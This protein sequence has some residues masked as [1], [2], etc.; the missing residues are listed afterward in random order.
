MAKNQN[1]GQQS[2]FGQ[3]SRFCPKMKISSKNQ[4]FDQK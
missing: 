4:D 2:N 1:G 3:K